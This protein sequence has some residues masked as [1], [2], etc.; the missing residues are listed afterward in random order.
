MR[1]FL[2]AAL[3]LL[4][5]TAASSEGRYL[6]REGVH[7]ALRGPAAPAIA[8]ELNRQTRD[9]KDVAGKAFKCA[10]A[11]MGRGADVT[12]GQTPTG[13]R[14]AFVSVLWK[15]DLAV[16]GVKNH[17]FVF[18]EG[19]RGYRLVGESA[20]RGE[21]VLAVKFGIGL[22]DFVTEERRHAGSRLGTLVEYPQAIAYDVPP[23]PGIAVTATN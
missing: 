8:R 2:L 18:L 1:P 9:C 6:D 11:D 3:A 10:F 16:D 5:P 17:G 15:S 12:Y 4:L 19:D 23:K 13:E 14:L 21:N 22:V 20:I 7:E